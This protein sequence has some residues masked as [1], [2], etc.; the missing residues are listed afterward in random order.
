MIQ[1]NRHC[2]NKAVINTK[3]SLHTEKPVSRQHESEYLGYYGYASYWGST[4]FWGAGMYPYTL[5]TGYTGYTTESGG[6]LFSANRAIK[7]A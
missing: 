7:K 1:V 6:Q 3:P 4:G 5:F 2:V